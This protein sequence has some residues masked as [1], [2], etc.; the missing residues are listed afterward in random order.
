MLFLGK[1]GDDVVPRNDDWEDNC[2]GDWED[3]FG[4]EDLLGDKIP[5]VRD[6]ISEDLAS[7]SMR[8]VRRRFNSSIASSHCASTRLSRR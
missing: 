1:W 2:R 4:G 3:G 5:I 7:Y 6:L 8:A